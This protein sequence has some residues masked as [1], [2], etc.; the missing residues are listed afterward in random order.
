MRRWLS[1]TRGAA[2]YEFALWLGVLTP[3]ILNAVDLGY[4]S[5]QAVQVRQAA[6]AGA[7]TALVLCAGA[8]STP[9]VSA[10]CANFSSRVSTAIQSTSL[11]SNVTWATSSEGWYCVDT[12]SSLTLQ[13]T[14]ET[15]TAGVAS[16]SM[17]STAPT[18]ANTNSASDY[19]LISTSFTFHPLFNRV[20]VASLLSSTI[21]YTAPVRVN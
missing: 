9:P 7:Q 5:F 16:G 14:A 8:N 21:T 18:C 11:G 15:I 1:S 13:G 17:A 19:V 3:L 12:T 20:T 2:A 10:N 6:Q 4:Y